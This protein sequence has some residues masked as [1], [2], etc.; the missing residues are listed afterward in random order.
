LGIWRLDAATDDSATSS[1]A[2]RRTAPPDGGFLL[3]WA[4]IF[5]IVPIVIPP[6]A[7]LLRTSLSGAAFGQSSQISLD[8]FA[9]V[10]RLGGWSVWANTLIFS[11]ASSA[12]AM[13]LGV[14]SAW[15]VSRTDALFARAAV[16]AAYLSL[17][18]PVMIKAIGWILLLGPNTGL[19]NLALRSLLHTTNPPI[20][21]FS[22]GG[23]SVLEGLFWAPVAMLLSMPVMAQMNSSLEEAASMAGAA[24]LS[25]LL[26]V[27]LPLAAPGLFA[28]LFLTLMRSLES[29]EVPLLIGEPGRI[30]TLTTAIYDTINRGLTPQ[31]ADASA[32]AILLVGVLVGPLYLYSRVVRR[33]ERYAVISGKSYRSARIELR[34]WRAAGSAVLLIFPATLLAPLGALLWASLLPIYEVPRWSSLAKISLENYREVLT[35]AQTVSSFVNGV[36]V[37]SLSGALVSAFVLLAAWVV[38]RRSERARWILDALSSMPLVFPGIVL[39]TALMIEFLGARV[40]PIY[41]TIWILVL[42]F[43]IQYIPYGIRIGYASIMKIDVQL[44]ESA[45]SGGAGLFTVLRR[46]VLPLALPSLL[47]VWIYVFLHAIKDLSIPVLLAGPNS[48]V[49]ANVILNLWNDGKIPE[50]GALSIVLDAVVLVFGGVFMHVTLKHR[51]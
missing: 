40:V 13:T 3:L 44:E 12:I 15:L 26:R 19:L 24:P 28:V 29:F 36:V 8:H 31:Y 37:A 7:F 18:S 45:V 47:A 42:A 43:F 6:L 33:R 39:A 20:A 9:R 16:V 49:I 48:Q 50:V 32:F 2:G 14:S 46:I 30:H 17:A 4:L 1:P 35:G 10:L 11:L 25:R 51:D 27:T 5:V 38:V 41:E 23:M 34:S 22:L 21:L